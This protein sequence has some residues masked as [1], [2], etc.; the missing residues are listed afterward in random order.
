V[1]SGIPPEETG[2]KMTTNDYKCQCLFQA[3]AAFAYLVTKAADKGEQNDYK[4]YYLT[5]PLSIH[6]PP[7]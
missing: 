1:A 6:E 7:S 4:W 3:S 2:N 5:F